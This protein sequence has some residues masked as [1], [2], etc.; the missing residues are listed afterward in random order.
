M[1]WIGGV[2]YETG[3]A[4][5]GIN[6]GLVVE[7]WVG[8]LLNTKIV[9]PM[10][11]WM[12]GSIRCRTQSDTPNEKWRPGLQNITIPRYCSNQIWNNLCMTFSYSKRCFAKS[13]NHVADL[14]TMTSVRNVT[15]APPLLDH[16]KVE[17]MMASFRSVSAIHFEFPTTKEP[18]S[19]CPQNKL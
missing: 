7:C 15:G 1:D 12:L 4:C 16:L 19:T 17:S 14:E 13:A 9:S 8:L 18:V 6:G 11:Y 3:M 2:G 5:L 10:H